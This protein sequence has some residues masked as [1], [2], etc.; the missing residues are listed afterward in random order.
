[1]LR[2]PHHLPETLRKR[3]SHLGIQAVYLFGSRAT[4]AAHALSDYDYA[5][6][7][8][9][10]GHKRGDLLYR[11]L[12]A[13][14]STI[15]PRTLANDVIDIV[16]LNDCGLELAFHI[17]RYGKVLFDANPTMRLEFETRTN[18]LYADYRPI[19]EEFDRTIL[20]SL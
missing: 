15:S 20:E 16:F 11:E 17:I 5:V 19:L 2:S 9:R 6:L 13:T 10:P 7:T 8:K 1:M 4:G 18:L 3:L 12:Y 14:F